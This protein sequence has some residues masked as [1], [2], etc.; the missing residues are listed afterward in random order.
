MNE[1]KIILHLLWYYPIRM[2]KMHKHYFYIE[3]NQ[4]HIINSGVENLNDKLVRDLT[5]IFESVR[6]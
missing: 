6:S 1:I 2:I 4:F 5:Q 3:S